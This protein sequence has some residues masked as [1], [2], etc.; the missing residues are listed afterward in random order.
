MYKSTA[1]SNQFYRRDGSFSTRP[2]VR[3][4]NLLNWEMPE[5]LTTTEQIDCLKRRIAYLNTVLEQPLTKD[6]RKQI[7]L[8]ITRR[9]SEISVLRP[10]RLGIREGLSNF[11]LDVV[12]ENISKRDWN[13]FVDEGIKRCDA[14]YGNNR[15]QSASAPASQ[16]GAG[17]GH[18]TE[19]TGGGTAPPRC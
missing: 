3:G 17:L 12:K 13:R 19:G 1:E 15:K 14:Y 6:E 5:E 16:P 2:S 4:V 11:I 7:G 18:D 9:C 8:E 10:R